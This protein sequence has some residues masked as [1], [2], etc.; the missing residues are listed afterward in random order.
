MDDAL[1]AIGDICV[2]DP[3]SLDV[4]DVLLNSY[5]SA[6]STDS[7]MQ[8]IRLQALKALWTNLPHW[9]DA[10]L[11]ERGRAVLCARAAGGLLQSACSALAVVL[12]SPQT[13]LLLRLGSREAAT[14]SAHF[15]H[16]MSAP[17]GAR[18]K[19]LIRQDMLPL[20]DALFAMVMDVLLHMCSSGDDA[21]Q[22]EYS[23]NDGFLSYGGHLCRGAAPWERLVRVRAYFSIIRRRAMCLFGKSDHWPF[24][25]FGLPLNQAYCTFIM[26]VF[27]S[28]VMDSVREC[29]AEDKIAVLM[30]WYVMLSTEYCIE[31]P[32]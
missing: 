11:C 23:F 21:G 31:V 6:N 8:D 12:A 7:R 19:A 1:D 3:Y 15:T 26:S 20:V 2:V 4:V 10:G 22:R 9:F 14:L 32:T 27:S 18:D 28:A 17:Y 29:P 24:E 16:L 25:I 30:E 5:K 13:A